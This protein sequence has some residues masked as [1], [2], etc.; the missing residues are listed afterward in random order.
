[1]SYTHYPLFLLALVSALGLVAVV[2][3]V[4][5]YLILR[6]ADRKEEDRN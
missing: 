4:A 1:V 2:A 5:G 3:G 6:H